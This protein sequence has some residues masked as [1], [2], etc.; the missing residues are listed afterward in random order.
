MMI[1]RRRRHG[2]AARTRGTP[3]FIAGVAI[4]TVVALSACSPSPTD[5]DARKGEAPKW[6]PWVS[7]GTTV[8]F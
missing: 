8:Q 6:D 7:A 2:D 4:A 3:A 1:A 5:E